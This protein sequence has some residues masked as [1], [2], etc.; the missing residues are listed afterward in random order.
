M[1][2]VL[3]VDDVEMIIEGLKVMID[4]KNLGF[5]ICGEAYNGEE[6]LEKAIKYLP[7]VIIT[8]IR[9]PIISGLELL[10]KIK[11]V[12]PLCKV[13]ILSGYND[14]EFAREALE[15]GA[16]AYL[17][18]PV[19]SEELKE[20]LQK[21][22]ESIKIENV[23][24]T[25][26]ISKSD[27]L[28]LLKN[29]VQ[30]NFWI[31]LVEGTIG[32]QREI[33]QRLETLKIKI[34]FK[35]YRMMVIFNQGQR[36]LTENR[37]VNNILQE[38]V[39]L[40]YFEFDSKKLI[41]FIKADEEI[42][43]E[44]KIK[45]VRDQSNSNLNSIVIGISDIY[46]DL[47]ES[48]KAFSEAKESIERLIF[49]CQEPGKFVV[50]NK[51]LTYHPEQ[52]KNYTKKK[53]A[54]YLNLSQ[55]D[56]I[57]YNECINSIFEDI[58]SGTFLTI[59]EIFS[60]AVNI[61]YFIRGIAREWSIS[62]SLY[63]S[64][65]YI[66][67]DYLK[68]T[69]ETHWKLKD[70]LIQSAQKLMDDIDLLPGTSNNVVYNKIIQYINENINV[71]T[72]DSVAE[73]FFLNS[74]YFSIYFKKHSGQTF[75]QYLTKIRMDKAVELVLNSDMKIYDIGEAVGYN[76]SQHFLKLFKEYTGA[77]PSEYK[78]ARNK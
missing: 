62:G 7:D 9:M 1:Y 64:D 41:G 8:D 5:E 18:K 39:P 54:I 23:R 69:Y 19:T 72:R 31:S 26:E 40:V 52:F 43:L 53:K 42:N 75:N 68:S 59:T 3:L 21:I 55:S 32:D 56:I 50:Y 78:K 13:I 57:N 47:S 14:F 60:E 76:S 15:K 48:N 25:E 73:N 38:I 22:K 49:L 66:N 34:E 12:A 35:K 6:G 46:Y 67:V 71:V 4:W 24:R 29:M 70:F 65:E 58:S 11:E 44:K 2:K 36:R 16:V 74:S 30:D 20:K 63:E 77:S 61:I 37:L 27:N 33:Q 17:L 51:K 28:Q 45:K 10:G